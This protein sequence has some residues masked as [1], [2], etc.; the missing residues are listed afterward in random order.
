MENP[1][2]QEQRPTRRTTLLSVLKLLA[3]APLAG[4]ARAAGPASQPA[5]SVDLFAMGDWGEDTA[6]QRQVASQM[7]R[8]AKSLSTPLSAVVLCGDS[9]YFALTGADDP[10]W[11]TLFEDMYDPSVLAVPFYSC[12]GNHDYQAN[13]FAAEFA[14]VRRHPQSRFKLP[15]RWYRRDIPAAHPLVTLLMLDS[16]KD[17][18]TELQWNQQINFIK[19]QLESPRAPWTICC[20]HHPMFSNGFFFSNPILQ[21]DWGQLFE[22]HAVDFYLAGH[23]HN[24]QHLE[25]RDWNES[26]V[27]AGGG[28]AHSHPLFRDDRG[29][30]RQ[31]FGFVHF[32]F[33]PSQVTVRLIDSTGAAVHAFDR[34]KSGRITQTLTTPN[35]P[36]QKNALRALLE[37]RN[38]PPAS[39]P[40]T[41]P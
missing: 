1:R 15:D 36:P 26:F 24:L 40:A 22:K 28:G 31:I 13:N 33:T 38:R 4:L 35:S 10:R 2:P 34:T 37:L 8:S 7:A 32:A 30:S 3:G 5:T 39:R 25:I 14:Y 21:R 27:I 17:S 11:K 19:E 20:A 41:R 9:F 23:E 12:L 18:L 16:N 6:A 29:F